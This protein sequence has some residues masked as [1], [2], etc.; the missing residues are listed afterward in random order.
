MLDL[1]CA[2]TGGVIV[3]TRQKSPRYLILATAPFPQ[4]KTNAKAE[5]VI[6]PLFLRAGHQ[7]P[8]EVDSIFC[9]N[10]SFYPVY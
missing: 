9:R 6:L 10:G 2:V 1:Q 7:Q 5:V 3:V 8:G 4:L